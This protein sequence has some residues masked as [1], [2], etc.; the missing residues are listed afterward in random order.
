MVFSSTELLLLGGFEC[1]EIGFFNGRNYGKTRSDLPVDV[2]I[3]EGR[4]FDY[5]KYSE[6]TK[7]LM[8]MK[9]ELNTKNPSASLPQPIL[10]KPGFFYEIFMQKFPDEHFVNCR[11]LAETIE[12]DSNI[13]IE[14]HNSLMNDGK[15]FQTISVLKF[16]RIN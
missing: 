6:D 7:I 14:F 1:G 2:K 12:L 13:T 5:T 10:I 8:T 3:T 16:N 15:F 11:E 4:T 9:A